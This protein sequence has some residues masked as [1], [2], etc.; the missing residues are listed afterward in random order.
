MGLINPTISTSGES[1]RAGA[2]AAE[3]RGAISAAFVRGGSVTSNSPDAIGI[4][5]LVGRNRSTIRA[6][7]AAGTTV[8]SIGARTHI[9]GLTGHNRDGGIIIAS[10]A[11]STVTGGG[12]LVGYNSFQTI[13]GAITNSYYDSTVCTRGGPGSA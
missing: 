5:G 13:S 8:T 6:S 3:N 11:A 12:C 4:G 7:Y 9:G 10:Y 2:L 1:N